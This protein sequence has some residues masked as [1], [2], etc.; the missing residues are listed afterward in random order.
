VFTVLHAVL[1]ALAAFLLGRAREGAWL[2][3]LLL[4]AVTETLQFFVPGRGP[5]VSD[6]LVDWSGV[7]LGTALLFA[8]RRRQGEGLAL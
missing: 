2:D 6:M 8:L 3:L 4:G 1:F 5:G 7:A